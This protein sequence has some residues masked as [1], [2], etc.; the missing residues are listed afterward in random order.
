MIYFIIYNKSSVGGGWFTVHGS[1]L[2]GFMSCSM[3]FSVRLWVVK[4]SEDYH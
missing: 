2:P 3:L 1:Q 4:A